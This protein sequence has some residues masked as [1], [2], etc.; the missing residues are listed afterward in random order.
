MGEIVLARHDHEARIAVRDTGVGIDPKDAEGLFTAY[1]QGKESTGA[2]GLGLGLAVAKAL[3]E[4]HGGRIAVHSEGRGAGSEFSFSIP[5]S[6]STPDTTTDEERPRLPSHRI[7]VVDDQPDVADSLA[8]QL[9]ELGQK[10]Q[11]AYSA[12]EA[13][14]QV[15]RYDPQLVFIDLSMPETTGVELARQLRKDFQAA[16]L[17]LVAMTG[18]GTAYLAARTKS[19][20]RSLLKPITVEKLI[21]ALGALT[22][23]G[24]EDS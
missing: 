17:T 12:E 1:R 18:H 2:G 21:E 7:V 6:S 13:L 8:A 9:E 11:V 20:D 4:A 16:R 23:N 3:V 14:E 15:H 22:P 24:G 19:F 5:M 10:V